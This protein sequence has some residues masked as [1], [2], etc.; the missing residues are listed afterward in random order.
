MAR[1]SFEVCQLDQIDELVDY[2]DQHWAKNHVLVTSRELLDWQHKAED[3]YNFVMARDNRSGELC[4]VL[5]YIPT[6]HFSE[7][8]KDESEIWLAIWKVN[9]GPGYVGL[10]LKL[11][12]YLQRES[13]ARNICSIG[14]SDVVK[15]MYPTLGYTVGRLVQLVLINPDVADYQI[16]NVPESF[17]HRPAQ[18]ADGY[19]LRVIEEADL[20][21]SL[22]VESFYAHKTQK[23]RAYFLNRFLN[24]PKYHYRFLGVYHDNELTAFLVTRITGHEGRTVVRVVDAQG[25]LSDV[26][27]VAG[28][29]MDLVKAE[30]HEYLDIM[31]YGMPEGMLI[32][33][34]FVNV[35]ESDS[36][37]IPDYFEP[38]VRKNIPIWFAQKKA[39]PED[40]FVLYKGDSDQDRPNQ[41]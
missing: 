16:A 18:N 32:D 23:D 35:N 8:L 20:A 5:G 1:F 15:E 41:M 29:L 11:L 14:I 36:L 28:Y 6:S 40:H 10:G 4:G 2:I 3:Q 25:R 19:Q 12:I 37:V 17:G 13:S 27:C 9:E 22:P 24:H 34:G 31:Q 39:E 33:A 38:F 30:G 7:G 26:A 21:T